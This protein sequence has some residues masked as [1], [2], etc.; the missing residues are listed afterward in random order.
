M[1][2]AATTKTLSEATS[3]A[4]PSKRSQQSLQTLATTM[5]AIAILIIVM[6]FAWLGY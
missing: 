2:A 3:R 4:Q 5:V 1:K 6:V